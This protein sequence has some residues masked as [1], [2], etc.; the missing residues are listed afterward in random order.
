M[1]QSE[2][3][4]LEQGPLPNAPTCSSPAPTSPEQR[5]VARF[6]HSKCCTD[7]SFTENFQI[8][9]AF[10]VRRV[11][12]SGLASGTRSRLLDSLL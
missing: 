2:P 10:E 4:R 12:D 5:S 3:G 8:R 9:A 11:R 7:S 6:P 1:E